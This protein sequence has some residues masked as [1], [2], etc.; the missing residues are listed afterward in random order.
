M[1]YFARFIIT[2]GKTKSGFLRKSKKERLKQA[3]PKP[4]DLQT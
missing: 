4:P 2:Q 1:R 3:T